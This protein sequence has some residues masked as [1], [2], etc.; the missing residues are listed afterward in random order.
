MKQMGIYTIKC[1]SNDKLYVGSAIDLIGR[2][3]Q[4]FYRLRNNKHG[5]L[6]LQNAFNKYGESNF[7]FEVVEIVDK[8]ENLI[9]AEQ[10]HINNLGKENQLFNLRKIAKNNLGLKHKKETIL[11]MIKCGKENGMYG[12]KHTDETKQKISQYRRNKPLSEQHKRSMSLARIGKKRGPLSE[13]TKQKIH[14]ANKGENS[15]KAKLNW[16]T[17]RQI[18]KEYFSGSFTYKQLGEKYGVYKTAI[19]KI[20]KNQ[21]WVE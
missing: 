10:Q 17:V 6:H 4:H 12:K 14:L 15:T 11:K 19:E 1:L 2:K 5:N 18:R 13:E 16:E 20:V 3:A 21:R 9:L 8:V 7:L